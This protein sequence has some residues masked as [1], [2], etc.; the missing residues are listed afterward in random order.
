MSYAYVQ[1]RKTVASVGGK[2]DKGEAVFHENVPVIL[3]L[4]ADCLYSLTVLDRPNGN[5]VDRIPVET[6]LCNDV[7]VSNLRF[8]WSM[9]SILNRFSE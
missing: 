6:L 4:N 2:N 9:T 3:N 7:L 5:A 8:G 1:R